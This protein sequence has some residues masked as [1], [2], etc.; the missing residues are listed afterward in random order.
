[1]GYLAYDRRK[2]RVNVVEMHYIESLSWLETDLRGEK[3]LPGR[4]CIFWMAHGENGHFMAVRPKKLFHIHR[5]D[6][7]TAAAIIEFVG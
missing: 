7:V 1:M 6:A 3:L 2:L 5:V 4:R